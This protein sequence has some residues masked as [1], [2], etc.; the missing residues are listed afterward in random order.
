MS[1][2]I[3][4]TSASAAK[5]TFW[6]K[7]GYSLGDAGSNFYW[8]V[9]EV[10]LLFFYTDVFGISPA[11]AG[12]IFLVA[13]IWDAVNDPIMGAIADRTRTRWGRFRPYLI[14]LP[15]PLAVAGVLAFTTPDLDSQGKVI[16]AW[17]T[18]F[19]VMMCYTGINIPYSALL[20]VLST[21]SQERTSASSF[22]FVAAFSTALVVQSFTKDFAEL[23]GGG[24]DALGWQLVMVIYGIV[25]SLFFVGTFMTTRERVEPIAEETDFKAELKDLARNVPWLILFFLGF[26]IL[27]ML[28]VRSASIVYYF[29]YFV[30]DESLFKW[31]MAIGAI[32]SIVGVAL[33][34]VLSK[35]FGKPRLY[36]LL[37]V[38]TTIINIAF[39]FVSAEDILMI[40]VL[41]TAF[42]LVLGPTAPVVWAMYADTADY[43]EWKNGRRATGL[44][45]SAATFGQKLGVAV[46]GS[47]TAFLLA[48]VGYVPNAEVQTPE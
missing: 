27:T 17:I 26:A 22:R 39:Y 19:F 36:F 45:F 42:S 12:T 18:Y 2:R 6:E 40:F 31:F 41:N 16:Y 37:I 28:F 5:L 10:F 20:G 13:R 46:A 25:A 34:P 33:T 23:L 48:Y 3:D 21:D 44:T 35:T 29:K 30:G 7:V 4:L 8:K 11:T 1:D 15:I 9:F 43:G 24:N 38:L 32:A 14:W 47:V